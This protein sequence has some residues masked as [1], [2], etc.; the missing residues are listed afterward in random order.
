M[1]HIDTTTIVSLS[2]VLLILTTSYL[3]SQRLLQPS[4][5]NSL[6]ILFVWHFFDF[7]IHTIFEGSF[8]YNCF[9]TSAAFDP[10]AHHPASIENFLGRPDRLYGARFGDNWGTKLWMV[11]AQADKRWAG[12]D[13]TVV[14]LELLTVLGAG[15]LALYICWGIVRRNAMIGFWMTVLATGE[16]YGGATNLL[17]FCFMTFAP[18]WLT[19]NQNL[20]A[21]N[22]MFKWVYL[23][24]FNMLWVFLPLYAM[25]YA[26]GDMNHAFLVRNGVLLQ[27]KV[28]R[29]RVQREREEREKKEKSK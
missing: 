18:E 29:E 2:V 12:A 20:D 17:A 15:P 23:V 16:L 27:S 13:L 6:R 7:L 1:D 22:F 24:F 3:L 5:P 8:L 4:T 14:S 9:F 11:Y 19:G 26:Y 21:S 10:A 25:Y 28:A